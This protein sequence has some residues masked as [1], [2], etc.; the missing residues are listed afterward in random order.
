MYTT[1]EIQDM[2]QVNTIVEK[3][4]EIAKQSIDF[5]AILGNASIT[6]FDAVTDHKFTT[7]TEQAKKGVNQVTNAA[8]KFIDGFAVPQVF[9]SGSKN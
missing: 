8:E 7:Y 1:K 3:S 2:F 6:Y 4:K 5:S 9:G